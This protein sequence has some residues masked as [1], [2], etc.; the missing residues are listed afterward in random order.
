MTAPSPSTTTVDEGRAAAGDGYRA[1]RHRQNDLPA[2]LI[3]LR[4]I[5]GALRR[6]AW[7]VCAAAVAGLA[8]GGALYVGAPPAYQAATSIMITN[9]PDLDPGSQM[10]DNVALAQSLQVA[11]LA[12]RKLGAQ[13]SVPIFARSYTVQAVTDQLMQITASASSTS[14]AERRANVVALAFMQFRS[15]VL[16]SAQQ[17]D[18]PALMQQIAAKQH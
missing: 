1:S 4:A 9:N 3:S 8:V 5:R 12:V 15:Q 10:Q 18:V 14:E 13:Q 6:R 7:F 17:V 2:G 11:G 16:A